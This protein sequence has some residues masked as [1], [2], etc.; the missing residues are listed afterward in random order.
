M[1]IAGAWHFRRRVT[2]ALGSERLIGSWQPQ[3]MHMNSA[4]TAGSITLF[5]TIQLCGA[6][7]DG[8]D[9][10]G[11]G[12]VPK[13]RCIPLVS[14]RGAATLWPQVASEPL[15]PVAPVVCPSL[16]QLLSD[17]TSRGRPR[18]CALM[19]LCRCR[20]CSLYYQ[21]CAAQ[22]QNGQSAASVGQIS[23]VH[24]GRGPRC[25]GQTHGRLAPVGRAD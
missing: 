21:H 19:A 8:Q 16:V 24:S 15:R 23:R 13:L 2:S 11:S 22:Q 6:L 5:V 4:I 10:G 7:S 18:K 20:R 3:Y 12:V 25:P 9:S 1:N 14:R 17:V